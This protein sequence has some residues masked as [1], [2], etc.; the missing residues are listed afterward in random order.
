[1]APPGQVRREG[2][3]GGREM[4][5][6][7]ESKMLHDFHA[8]HIERKVDVVLVLAAISLHRTVIVYRRRRSD[9]LHYLV[10]GEE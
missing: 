5:G 2:A 10:G 7:R 4:S 8:K 6:I 9:A 1:M 3:A